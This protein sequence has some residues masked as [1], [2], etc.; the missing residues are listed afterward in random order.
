M[1]PH[2]L[3]DSDSVSGFAPAGSE[4]ASSTAMDDSTA[5]SGTSRLTAADP[6][7]VHDLICVGFGPASLAI[8]V[9]LH[10]ALEAGQLPADA[11][12]PKVLFLEKQPSFSWHAG[13]LLPG[14]R[15]QISF[16]KD[17]ATLRDPR[18]RFTFLNFLHS[19]GRLVEFINLGTFLP[20][21]SEYQDYLCWA[22]SFFNNVVQYN[23]EVL[24]ISP[25]APATDDAKGL[26]QPVKE[27]VTTCRD[28]RTGDLHIHRARH[29]I[30]AIGGQPSV[31]RTLPAGHP[32]VIHSSQ[33]AHTVPKILT[34]PTA[35]YRVA[36]IGAGQSAAE[37]FSH[38]HTLFPRSKTWL[39]MKSD[40]LRPSDDSPL[41]VGRPAPD[42]ELNEKCTN[43]CD[44]KYQFHLQS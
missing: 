29:V 12:P 5:G 21:R 13:M 2:S 1:S 37:I 19:Q 31:P 35:E 8:A 23:S 11:G 15:M 7:C 26:A 38:I 27:F 14:A 18:S 41:Y 17:L 44:F 16:L 43:S 25:G 32:R 34:D 10:D 39:V 3:R 22:A 20:S 4:T 24:S 30:V 33:Y 9:A 40:F 36:V 6:E 28:T 42:G